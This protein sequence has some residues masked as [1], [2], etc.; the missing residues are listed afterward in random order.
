MLR[1]DVVTLFPEFFEAW[2]R[3][4]VCGRA[5]DRGLVVLN[6]VNPRQFVGDV[7]QTVDDRPYGGGP[8][9]VMMA[10]PLRDAV[11]HCKKAS[12]EGGYSP[13]PVVL[14]SPSGQAL[15]QAW[16]EEQIAGVAVGVEPKVLQFTLV[17]GRYEGVDQRFIDGWVDMEIS[18]GDFVLSGGEIAALAVMDALARRLPGALGDDQS[19]VQE[20]F[21]QGLLE[22]PQYTRPEVFEGRPVPEV[23][24]SGHHG[25]ITD[26]RFSESLARTEAR[27]P[28]LLVKRKAK[29]NL[30]A[31]EKD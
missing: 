12:Q 25:K 18:L 17:C 10:G 11:L 23:L 31:P 8:G 6:V 9:M 4:G 2:A 7:H 13:G 27:R 5:V 16:V 21:M 20:S 30:A 26:W 19:S 3:N 1:F 15:E 22:F 28:D 24:L 14:M 29:P